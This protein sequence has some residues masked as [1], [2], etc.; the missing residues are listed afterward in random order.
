M[1]IS[2]IAQLF[3]V[4]FLFHAGHSSEDMAL[5]VHFLRRGKLRSTDGNRCTMEERNKFLLA[6]RAAMEEVV[7]KSHEE[8]AP[9]WCHGLCRLHEEGEYCAVVHPH[10]P[11]K[12]PQS[13]IDASIARKLHENRMLPVR[14]LGPQAHPSEHRRDRST[15]DQ[16]IVCRGTRVSFLTRVGDYLGADMVSNECIS[17]LIHR[18]GISCYA[19]PPEGTEPLQLSSKPREIFEATKP[20]E[21]P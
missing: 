3:C 17:F 16:K 10:C 14:E 2:L 20:N 21:N 7:D 12:I 1:T 6:V 13:S 5:K 4:L 8:E 9:W 18:F 11:L 15:T 19:V